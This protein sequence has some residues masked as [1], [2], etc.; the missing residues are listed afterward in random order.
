MIGKSKS[1]QS[2]SKNIKIIDGVKLADWLREFLNISRWFALKI[3]ITSKFD[4][5]IAPLEHWELI[6]SQC[7]NDKPLPPELFIASRENACAALE[8][9]FSGK[10]N[11]LFFFSESENDVNDFVAAYLMTLDKHKAQEFADQCLFINDENTWQIIS[12]LRRSHVLVASL[13]LGLDS[14]QKQNFLT[15]I[16]NKGH[17]VIIPI[18]GTCLAI[19][20]K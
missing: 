15:T 12:E 10:R 11:K 13:R 7:K 1:K 2:G 8:D 17:R 9:V 6:Q 20:P 3:G 18:C 14:E 4:S 5:I 16:I 19:I